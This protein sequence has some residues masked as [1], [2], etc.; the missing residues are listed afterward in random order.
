MNMNIAELRIGDMVMLYKSTFRLEQDSAELEEWFKKE[1]DSIDRV[2]DLAKTMLSGSGPALAKAIGADADVEAVASADV[3]TLKK[4]YPNLPVNHL[5]DL[6]LGHRMAVLLKEYK[7]RSE[8]IM[9]ETKR[10]R[11]LND[12]WNLPPPGGH[13]PTFH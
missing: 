12:A 8:A 10:S 5:Q 1:W 9:V 2:A 6:A 11:R 4:Q 13:F 3:V 7:E